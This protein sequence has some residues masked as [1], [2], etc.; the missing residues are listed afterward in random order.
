MKQKMFFLGVYDALFKGM[1]KQLIFLQR[2]LTPQRCAF[3]ERFLKRR[4]FFHFAFRK[5]KYGIQKLQ[6]GPTIWLN[7]TLLSTCVTIR[8]YY[9]FF[10]ETSETEGLVPL[11]DQIKLLELLSFRPLISI[12]YRPIETT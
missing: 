11:A 10:S 1:P 5:L 12:V 3:S 2:A 7:A 4:R 8:L 9:L 6:K